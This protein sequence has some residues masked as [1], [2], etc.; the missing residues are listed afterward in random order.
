M[1]LEDGLGV[2]VCVALHGLAAAG[3]LSAHHSL[4]Y[5]ILCSKGPA[6]LSNL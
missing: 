1:S 4:T 6:F 3:L 2:M 5:W